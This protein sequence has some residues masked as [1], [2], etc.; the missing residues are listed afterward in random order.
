MNPDSI[1]IAI[2]GL[3]SADAISPDSIRIEVLVRTHLQYI[4]DISIHDL[5][6]VQS[7]NKDL[8]IEMSGI[9]NVST[10]T[11]SSRAYMYSIYVRIYVHLCIVQYSIQVY[12]T[13][14]HSCILYST[15]FMCIVQ[16]SIHVH[17]YYTIQHSCV[18][19][20]TAFMY[21]YII[22]YSIHVYCT[23]QHSCI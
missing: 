23:V 2:F 17:V 6:Q 5:H 11:E 18:L 16:Y 1:R 21:M 22:Q 8:R 4:S 15:A 12:Y 10:I 14:Q 13:V 20:S 3:R 7:I 9:S 19:Y